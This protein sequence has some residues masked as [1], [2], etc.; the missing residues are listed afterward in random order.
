MIIKNSKSSRDFIITKKGGF[1]LYPLHIQKT[2]DTNNSNHFISEYESTYNSSNAPKSTTY[3][4]INIS[5]KNHSFSNMKAFNEINNKNIFDD[6]GFRQKSFDKLKNVN[7]K[8]KKE[9]NKRLEFIKKN[10][11]TNKDFIAEDYVRYQDLKKNIKEFTHI[12]YNKSGIINNKFPLMLKDI[13]SCEILYN[14]SKNK[15]QFRK[16]IQITE[17]EDVNEKITGAKK[18]FL[19]TNFTDNRK[20]L[21]KSNLV[22]YSCYNYFKVFCL[23]NNNHFNRKKNNK[24]III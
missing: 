20:N 5:K 19:K 23:A 14:N 21:W 16:S 8:K 3:I 12:N 15:K 10:M 17:P 7:D 6:K 1:K 9:I 4:N 24:K 18:V 13:K 22:K 2:Q 11:L